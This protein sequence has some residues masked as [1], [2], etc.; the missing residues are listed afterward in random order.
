M[1]AG[2]GCPSLAST[3]PS[4]GALAGGASRALVVIA[5]LV[6]L[7]RR[8]REA[9]P[10]LAVFALP[11][12]LPIATGRQ[13]GEPADPAVSGG[14]GGH[15]RVP[16]AAAA[17][18][19]AR[20]GV[21]EPCPRRRQPSA[22][23]AL[24]ELGSWIS[25]R[26]VEWLLLGGGRRC[27]RCRRSTRATTPRR[28]ENIAFFYVPFGAAVRDAARRALDARAAAALPRRGGRR[29]RC[30]SRASASS[31]TTARRCS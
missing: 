3:L 9:F 26:G 12:R 2:T 5:V 23:L 25:P 29:W 17:G 7:M 19:G 14:R 21:A 13:D 8:H 6:V 27:T 20:A 4:A 1:S 30:C 24:R 11:F 22:D 15:A 16:A 10:L 18:P 28:A 31:S